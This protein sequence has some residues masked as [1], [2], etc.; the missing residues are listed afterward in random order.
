MNTK[1]DYKLEKKGWVLID[2]LAGDFFYDLNTSTNWFRTTDAPEKA[3]LFPSRKRAVEVAKKLPDR[4]WLVA[5]IHI[6]HFV[7][8]TR[9]VRVGGRKG[10]K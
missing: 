3:C 6:T 7:G 10:E 1:M 4:G 2:E 8:A 5:P 9:S